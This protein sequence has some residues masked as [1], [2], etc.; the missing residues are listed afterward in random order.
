[1]SVPPAL[2]TFLRELRANNNRPWFEANRA[3]YER[4]V[5]DALIALV[6]DFSGPL[7]DMAP[8]Y[9]ADPRPNGGSIFRIYRDTRF[10][11]DKTPY[12]TNAAVHFRHRSGKDVHA[13]GF[14]LHFSPDEVFGGTGIWQP[15]P[16]TQAKIRDAIVERPDDWRAATAGLTIEGD[17]LARAPRGYDP[18]HPLIDDLRR[19]DFLTSIRFDEGEACA[20]DFLDRY[21]AFGRTSVP[22]MRFLTEAVGLAW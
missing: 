14:Y 15:D 1:V 17:C 5:R 6:V 18:A 9:V 10:S 22:F 20:P 13:P 2:F 16:P 7:L 11:R 3:R 4:D 21:A 8:H 19:K 12:K